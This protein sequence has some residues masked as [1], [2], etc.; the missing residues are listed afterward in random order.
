MLDFFV[1]LS[2]CFTA[3]PKKYE[4]TKKMHFC[5]NSLSKNCRFSIERTDNFREICNICR[6]DFSTQRSKYFKII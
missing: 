3:F 6:L 4:K 5:S 2:R 1:G